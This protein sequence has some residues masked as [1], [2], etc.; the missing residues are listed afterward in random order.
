MSAKWTYIGGL[1]YPGSDPIPIGSRGSESM[2]P[3]SFVMPISWLDAQK[4]ENIINGTIST[5]WDFEPIRCTSVTHTISPELPAGISI[6]D[7]IGIA[8]IIVSGMS[9]SLLTTIINNNYTDIYGNKE[10]ELSN[11]LPKNSMLTHYTPLLTKYNDYIITVIVEW[12]YNY[13]FPTISKDQSDWILRIWNNWITEKNDVKELA[14]Q[15]VKG[16]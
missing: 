8:G 11:N 3:G 2:T 14:A 12:E 7:D 9:N 6:V 5:V 15:E 13:F 16:V 10:V 1:R 4:G